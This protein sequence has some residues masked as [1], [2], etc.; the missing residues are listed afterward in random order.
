MTQFC[1]SSFIAVLKEHAKDKKVSNEEFIGELFCYICS[2]CGISNK[3]SENYW[4]S[5]ELASLLLNRK[6]D[7][8]APIRQALLNA[9]LDKLRIGLMIFYDNYLNEF[10]LD[11]LKESTIK[12]YEND[13]RYNKE[14]KDAVRRIS[15][16]YS[17]ITYLLME[18]AKVNNKI[19]EIKTNI[20]KQ[21]NN[22]INYV[23]DDIIRIGFN[24]K[25]SKKKKIIVIPVD[26][27]FHMHVS[28]LGEKPA[29][30]SENTI[31]GKWILRMNKSGYD[32]E[33]IADFVNKGRLIDD[34]VIGATSSIVVKN[35]EFYLLAI[36][37][38]DENCKAHATKE[39]ITIAIKKLLMNYDAYGNGYEMFIPLIGTGRSR[40]KLSHDDSFNLIKE[41]L[42]EN[43]EYLNGI[44]NIV[45]YTHDQEKMEG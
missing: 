35:T 22:E 7:I 34:N 36:S 23:I 25:N 39:D 1:F 40:A 11:H 3:N 44:V 28:G 9:K 14:E 43:K 20:Y 17:L 45:I 21:G 2:V 32:E 10:E 8:P 12:L 15:N 13:E 24:L 26:T 4:N 16:A 6:E 19:T 27:D 33:K 38:F 41:T 5:K 42:L 37:K 31:H 18:T 30:V 29:V